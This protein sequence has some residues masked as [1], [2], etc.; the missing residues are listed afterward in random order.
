MANAKKCDICGGF[1]DAYND[2]Y[3]NANPNYITY[4]FENEYDDHCDVSL[5]ECCPKC[6]FE[7]MFLIEM[8]KTHKICDP[9]IVKKEVIEKYNLPVS[10]HEMTI[11][12]A[13]IENMEAENEHN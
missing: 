12:D 5:Y 13:L 6:M 3:Y 11:Y 7:I 9:A 1:Y 2:N 10:E 8:I 4:G